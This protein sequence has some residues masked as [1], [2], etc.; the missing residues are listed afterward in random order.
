VRMK[1]LRAS[2]HA[3]RQHAPQWRSLARLLGAWWLS[4]SPYLK[5]SVTV[6]LFRD[7]AVTALVPPLL[8]D[9]C[10]RRC[11]LRPAGRSLLE[12]S[13]DPMPSLVG[14]EHGSGGDRRGRS[15]NRWGHDRRRGGHVNC[16]IARRSSLRPASNSAIRDGVLMV[17]VAHLHCV[18]KCRDM[19]R[20]TLAVSKFWAQ[21]KKTTQCVLSD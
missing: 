11:V 6:D 10:G 17:G 1:P 4:D 12:Y 7:K 20:R 18:L 8:V 16:P 19:Q 2:P 5:A 21:N 13:E 3:D 15:E 14:L 9:Q